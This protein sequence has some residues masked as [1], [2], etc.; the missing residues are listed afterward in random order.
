[1]VVPNLLLLLALLVH[2]GGLRVASTPGG[3]DWSHDTLCLSLAVGDT[4]VLE[5]INGRNLVLRRGVLPGAVA[6]ARVV[7]APTDASRSDFVIAQ[8]GLFGRKWPVR[9]DVLVARRVV[10]GL[11]QAGGLPPGDSALRALSREASRVLSPLRVAVVFA[12]SGVVAVPSGKRPFWDLDG[13]G[14]LD[15]RRNMDSAAPDPELDSLLRWIQ[16]RGAAFPEVVVVGLPNRTGWTLGRD[17]SKGDSTLVLSRR[18]NL[19][20][21]DGD[22]ALRTYVVASRRGERPDTFQVRAYRDGMHR[23]A[24]RPGGMRYF[25]AAATDWVILPG[26]DAGAFGFT[27]WWRLDAPILAFPGQDGRLPSRMLARI[28]AREIARGFGLEDDPDGSNLMCPM[29]RP[30]A[31]TPVVTP[32]QWRMLAR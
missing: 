7:V 21:R 32:A 24:T 9:L 5:A 27:P 10:V 26:F 8:G 13:D 31:A 3:A 22:G 25:H 19:P 20:W 1:M 23:L 12:D 30:D 6:G 11:R 15:L 29:T 14:K 17:L 28:V 4:A 16:S 2:G 18:A